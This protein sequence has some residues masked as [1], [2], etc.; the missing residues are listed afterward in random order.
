MVA[1]AKLKSLTPRHQKPKIGSI[2][3]NYL[4]IL[5][6]TKGKDAFAG[7][8]EQ[9]ILFTTQRVQG[10]KRKHHEVLPG[11]SFFNKCT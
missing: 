7:S 11:D 1:Q 3:L 8:N 5:H 6:R 4:D 9:R 2:E 10:L